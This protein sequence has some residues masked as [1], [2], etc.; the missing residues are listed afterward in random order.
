MDHVYH[1]QK[2]KKN[3]ELRFRIIQWMREWFN[4]QNFLEVE[5][6]IILRLPGQEPYLSPMKLN[7]HNENGR[8]FSG[9]M[10]TSPEY[11]MKKML[12]AGFDKIY[13]I[14]KT[15]RD[16][17]S[18]GGTH[19]PEFTMIEWYRTGAGIN[20]LMDDIEMLFEFISGKLMSLRGAQS[21]GDG[22]RSSPIAVSTTEGLPR[23]SATAQFLAMTYFERV[24]MRDLWKKY[25]GINLDEY[26]TLEKMFQ[27]CVERG[28]SPKKDEE[29][30]N[31]FYRI[32]LN[33]I[34]P[35]LGKEKPTI[36]HHYPM[37]MAALAKQSTTDTGYAERMEVYVDG[38]ELANGFSELTDA[39]EQLGRLEE[40]KAKRKR[41]KKD[42]FDIDMEF[43]NAV[44]LMPESA[45]I[46]LGIDR[47]T[48]LFTGCKNIDD[49]L[50]L[51]M[52]K[53]M[54]N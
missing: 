49:V 24:H 54:K 51:P 13:S 17:E 53:L 8:E 50:V 52:S 15:F 48:Q 30:E 31:L 7:I 1:I 22:G 12:A 34:E 40:E 33:E 21:R 39:D 3:L 9:Y 18:F 45:G 16:Y 28:Y 38:L 2:N 23:H 27:L 11:T 26:L 46:A 6:P 37:Q 14:C 35:R 20:A 43:I 41:L 10:H 25:I 29:Y 32:F 5:T 42:V 36:V 19:N 4:T 44:R 47:L